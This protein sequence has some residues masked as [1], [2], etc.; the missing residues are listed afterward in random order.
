MY[1]IEGPDGIQQWCRVDYQFIVPLKS[2]TTINI[3]CDEEVDTTGYFPVMQ[4]NNE[5]DQYETGTKVNVEI[6]FSNVADLEKIV[7]MGFKEGFTTGYNIL[8]ELLAI[9][10]HTSAGHFCHR[11]GSVV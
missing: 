6:T 11:A 3:F 2:F 9:F 5:F 4:W 8:D 7:E 10:S 1:C